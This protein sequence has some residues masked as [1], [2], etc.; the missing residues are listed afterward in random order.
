MDDIYDTKGMSIYQ[1][2]TTKYDLEM[3]LIDEKKKIKEA[4][5]NEETKKKLTK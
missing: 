3:S 4:L 5:N 2:L 1:V